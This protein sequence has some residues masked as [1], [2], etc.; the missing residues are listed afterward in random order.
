MTTNYHK[1]GQSIIDQVDLENIQSI[2]HCAT[3]LRLEVNQREAIDD[4]AIEEIDQVK[5]VFFNSG[6]YQIILGTGT[7]NKVYDAIIA[8]YPQLSDRESTVDD[9]KERQETGII[10][11]KISE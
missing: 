10:G 6:Q 7:V 9:M 11:R 8:D 2:T 1:I 4:E 5:G 3:R